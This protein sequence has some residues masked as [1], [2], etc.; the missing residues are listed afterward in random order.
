[1]FLN[2]RDKNCNKLLQMNLNAVSM[3]KTV[4]IC[5]TPV[6]KNRALFSKLYNFDLMLRSLHFLVVLSA[7]T[8]SIG[9]S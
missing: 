6:E 5:Q 9:F 8:G 7:E 2:L 1:M 3:P 4:F